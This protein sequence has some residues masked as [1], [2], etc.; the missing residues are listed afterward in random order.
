MGIVIIVIG[1]LAI[2]GLRLGVRVMVAIGVSQVLIMLILSS[3]LT[4]HSVP[5]VEPFTPY[6]G[7]SPIFVAFVSLGFL[8]YSGY[9]SI[10][11]LAEEAKDPK[12]NY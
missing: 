2:L 6:V 12:K 8:S 9:G 3:V 4:V 11:P 5:S 1:V 10:L 7:W